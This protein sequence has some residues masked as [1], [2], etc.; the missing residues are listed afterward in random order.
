MAG[1]PQVP[2]VTPR[3]PSAGP[4]ERDDEYRRLRRWIAVVGV[5][6]LIGVGGAAYAISEIESTKDQ[7]RKDDAAVAAV[8]EDLE[9]MREQLGGRVDSLEQQVDDAPSAQEVERLQSQVEALDK[10][11]KRLDEESGGGAEADE[12]ATRL[13]DLEQLVED[14]ENEDNSNN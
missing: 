7:N 12:L 9:V 11:V 5:I 6:A 8:R 1:P 10:R 2:A 3:P 4:P 14:L 13:D